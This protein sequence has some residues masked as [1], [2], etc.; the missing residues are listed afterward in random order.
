[1]KFHERHP[2]IAVSALIVSLVSH[3][4][5]FAVYRFS[6]WDIR[7]FGDFRGVIIFLL[8]LSGS[9]SFFAFFLTNS[10]LFRAV[11][12]L[13]TICVVIIVYSFG[14]NLLV[15]LPLLIGLIYEV[16]VYETVPVNAISDTVIVAAAILLHRAGARTLSFANP[17]Y[18][19]DVLIAGATMAAL[20][21][22]SCLATFYREQLI[23]V[24]AR[25]VR[26]DSA[27]TELTQTHSGFAQIANTARE[28]S[29]VDERNRITREIHDTIGYSLTN[30]VMILEAAQD[31]AK[32]GPEILR[33]KLRSAHSQTRHGLEETRRAL[34][35][36]REKEEVHTIGLSAVQ[37]M[38]D[39]FS[40]A[41]GILVNVEYG[42]VPL[43]SGDELDEAIFHLIQESLVN[44]FRHGHAHHISVR[45]WIESGDYWVV[46]RDDGIGT[47][48]LADGIGMMG[49]RERLGKLGGTLK[50]QNTA[51]GF[52][53]RASISKIGFTE[54]T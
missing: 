4:L 36:L 38:I 27:V 53:I 7:L 39:I 19:P 23:R 21:I 28:V 34:Y 13:R 3:G 33:E 2:N 9:I 16:N 43:T 18:F 31:L 6:L 25:A 40:R 1:M 49:M 46:I 29:A 51:D 12:G 35:L 30:V 24:Q 20:S 48:N 8:L 41:S 11:L 54:Q 15:C 26:L 42:N 17:R 32:N 45:L 14:I 37:R 47:D 52:E 44:A 5:T 50:A 22:S 10:V